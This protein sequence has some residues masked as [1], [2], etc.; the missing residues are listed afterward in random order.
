MGPIGDF[1]S[2]DALAKYAGIVWQDRQPGDF[3]GKNR[4]MSCARAPS[5]LYHRDDLERCSME[6]FRNQEPLWH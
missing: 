3:E 2:N 5:G 1:R 6:R 4:R